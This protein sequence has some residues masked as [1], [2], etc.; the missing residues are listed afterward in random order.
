MMPIDITRKGLGEEVRA[1][2]NRGHV[3]EIDSIRRHHIADAVAPDADMLRTLMMHWV[4]GKLT[5]SSIVD[6]HLS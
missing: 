4:H 6:E 2:L 5:S 1:L 3:N